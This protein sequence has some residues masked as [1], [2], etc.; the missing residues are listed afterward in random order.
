MTTWKVQLN[1]NGATQTVVLEANNQREALEMGAHLRPG[2]R[3]T[4]AQ[5]A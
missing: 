3:A 5:R 4:S 1:K 2:Y